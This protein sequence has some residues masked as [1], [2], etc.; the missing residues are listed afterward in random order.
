MAKKKLAAYQVKRDF[1]KTS[2][3]SGKASTTI[4]HKH[5]ASRLH[6][7]RA[8]RRCIQVV[9]GDEGAFLD[10]RDKRLAVEVEGHPLDYGD[11]EGAIPMSAA[12]SAFCCHVRTS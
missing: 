6:Y 12:S 11:F 5:A 3:P 7:D 8:S 1:D 10:P 9:G 4:V 2:E